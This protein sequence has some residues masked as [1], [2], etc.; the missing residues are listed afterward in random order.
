M[1][2]NKRIA[3]NTILLYIRLLMTMVIN[4]YTSRIVLNVLGIEDFGIYN[5]VGGVVMMLGFFNSSLLTATQRFLNYEIGQGNTKR[6]S[7]IFATSLIGNYMIGAIIIVLS[8]TLG[9]WCVYH[10]LVIPVER[11][12]AA[13]WVF[14]F[15]IITFVISII[16]SSYHAAIIAHERMNIY[17]Y[18]SIIDVLFKL[19]I[20]FSLTWMAF[21][22]LQLY[23]VLLCLSAILIQL[24]YMVYCRRVFVECRFKYIWD[25]ELLKKMFGFSGWMVAGTLTNTLTSQGVNMAINIFFNPVYNAARAISQQV[26]TAVN[27]FAF[28]FMLAVRPQIVKSYSGGEET[29]MYKLVFISSKMSFYLLFVLSLPILLRT[30]YLLNLWLKLVPEYAVLFTQLAII[31]I[32]ITSSYSPIAAVS[33]A[34]GKIKY[35]QLIISAGFLC[36]FI[37]TIL[38]Y[39]LGFPAYITYIVAITLAIAG[40]FARLLELKHTLRFPM[41]QYISEVTIRLFAV[42]VVSVIV[43]FPV[44]YA[45][46]QSLLHFVYIGLLSVLSI[47]VSFW[48]LGLNTFEKQFILLKIKQRITQK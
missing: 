27:N 9:L 2:N 17:A 16:S 32:L 43:S 46:N 1:T 28:N 10:Y 45:M 41:K 24:M 5:V 36:I 15:S 19:V 20:A 4:L 39:H 47:T 34:S 11:F 44:A 31:E 21:D 14:H 48:L 38:L 8:E 7:D 35:Y 6:L 25:K 13:L 18:L 23:A 29:Y 12:P 42:A 22:K 40:L 3:K 26:C 33:Q 30:E 37:F